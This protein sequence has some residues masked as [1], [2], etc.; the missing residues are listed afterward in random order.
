AVTVGLEIERNVTLQPAGRIESVQVVGEA[1]AVVPA[2]SAGAHFSQP[3]V[4]Q[5]AVGRTLSSIAELSPGLTNVTPNS[6]QVSV[7][8]AFAFDTIFL[9]NG[10]DVDDN[11]L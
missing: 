2:P 8:G 7:N 10:V 1:P 6:G 9:V 4:E 5:L 3:E 11:L